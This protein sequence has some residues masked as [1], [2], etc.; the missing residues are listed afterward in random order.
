MNRG[1]AWKLVCFP[2]GSI[3][4]SDPPSLLLFLAATAPEDEPW[5]WG[6]AAAFKL[7]MVNADPD[8]TLSK[9][10]QQHF[11]AAQV[12]W[13]STRF[14]PIEAGTAPGRSFNVGG[15]VRFRIEIEGACAAGRPAPHAPDVAATA[16]RLAAAMRV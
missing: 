11:F 3:P 4:R 5:G 1:Y 8:A 9:E 7:S 10:T 16:A 13:G 2:H 6:R 15:A 14:A 12:D